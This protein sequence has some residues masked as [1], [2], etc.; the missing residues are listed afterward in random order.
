M[1]RIYLPKLQ[2]WDT[3][4][5]S[6]WELY[7]QITRVLRARVWQKII[8]FDGERHE[9]FVYEIQN[10]D[11][12]NIVFTKQENIMKN[13]ELKTEL[14][15]YQAFPN[16]L[17]KMEYIIQKC[18]E[19]GYKK[20]T[21]FQSEHSQ[22]LVISEGKEERLRKIATEATEQC[23]GNII[24][25]IILWENIEGHTSS[26]DILSL[27]CDPNSEGKTLG[28]L[29]MSGHEEIHIYVWPEWGFSEDELAACTKRGFHR[30]SLGERVFRA[31]T[32]WEVVGF[33]MSQQ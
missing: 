28:D 4:E 12:R 27:V 1:Q 24:P 18:S 9:D 17:S 26:R 30:V 5:I 25:E 2:L 23:G 31:E 8:F 3:L 33:F 20:I 11:K 7:H 19:I 15:L 16:K 29:P 21:F 10:I 14:H 6:D 32:V 13:A 22:K